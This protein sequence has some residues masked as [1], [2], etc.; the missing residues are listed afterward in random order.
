VAL[1]GRGEVALGVFSGSA[2]AVTATAVALVVG[3]QG[4]V[5]SAAAAAAAATTTMAE[6]NRVEKCMVDCLVGWPPLLWV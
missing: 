1:V 4:V 6:R 5:A 3:A 2:A